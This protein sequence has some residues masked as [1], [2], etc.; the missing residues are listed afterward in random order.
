MCAGAAILSVHCDTGR[1]TQWAPRLICLGVSRLMCTRVLNWDTDS[2]SAREDGTA[3]MRWLWHLEDLCL[4]ESLC[5]HAMSTQGGAGEHHGT[6]TAARVDIGLARRRAW[7]TRLLA[8]SPLQECDAETYRAC[9]L[10][11]HIC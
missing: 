5:A 1:C 10:R 11:A 4:A 2:A 3:I 9:T 6:T 8:M 7:V